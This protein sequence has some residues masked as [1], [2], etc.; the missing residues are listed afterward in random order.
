MNTTEFKTQRGKQLADFQKQY[1]DL[2]T[3]YST[4]VINAVKEQDRS[5]QCILIKQ[6]LDTNKKITALLNAFNSNVDPGTCKSNPELKTRLMADL[7]Q[8]KKEHEEIQQ[9]REQ[10]VGLQNAL[11]RTKEKTTEINEMFSWY[12]VLVGLSVVILIFIIIFRTSS[13]MFNT[14]PSAPVFAGSQG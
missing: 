12:A 4:A 2:K 6:V 1:T 7:N 5:K 3:E 14:Q 8:Y 9:G 10:L 11:E 13:S